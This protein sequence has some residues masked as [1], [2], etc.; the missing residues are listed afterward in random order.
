MDICDPRGVKLPSDGPSF[1]PSKWPDDQPPV[2]QADLQ[3]C[4]KEEP[5]TNFVFRIGTGETLSSWLYTLSCEDAWAWRGG[6]RGAGSEARRAW[7]LPERAATMFAV[8]FQRCSRCLAL[9]GLRS[10]PMDLEH[11]WPAPD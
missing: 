1:D 4:F 11:R 2:A 5:L 9:R 7:P 6:G 8:Q 3:D 10:S